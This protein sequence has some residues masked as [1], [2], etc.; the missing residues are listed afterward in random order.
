MADLLR[1]N[2]SILLNLAELRHRA[3]QAR[4]EPATT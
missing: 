1:S 4:V 3:S 2:D